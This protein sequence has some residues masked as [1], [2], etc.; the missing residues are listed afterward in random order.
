MGWENK[1]QSQAI[2]PQIIGLIRTLREKGLIFQS[3]W[4]LMA[5]PSGAARP[6]LPCAC[7]HA[8]SLSRVWLF[9]TPWTV[10]NQ[11]SLSMGFS[12]QEYWSGLS[13]LPTGDLLDPGIEPTS[14]VAPSLQADSLPLCHRGKPFLPWLFPAQAAVLT[15][16]FQLS[17][18]EPKGFGQYSAYEATK[19]Y[20]R[21][22][23]S[24]LEVMSNFFLNVF[25]IFKIA[26]HNLYNF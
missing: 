19:K 11:A 21:V 10:A 20:S 17:V 8:K 3:S 2:H 23:S 7:V 4:V 25:S 13:W 12:R 5:E 18:V 22:R 24:A 15:W 16:I 26:Y 14:P 9:A 6:F 1:P